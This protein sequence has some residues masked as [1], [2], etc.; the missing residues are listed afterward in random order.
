MRETDARV[1]PRGLPLLRDLGLPVPGVRYGPSQPAPVAP[2]EP[3]GAGYLEVALWEESARVGKRTEPL[4]YGGSLYHYHLVQKREE[5]GRIG[6]EEIPPPEYW[7]QL[8]VA[9]QKSSLVRM[10]TCLLPRS[11][12]WRH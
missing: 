4:D 7:E 11:R 10:P 9:L 5:A 3:V 6:V 8:Q 1:P 2:V 12:S